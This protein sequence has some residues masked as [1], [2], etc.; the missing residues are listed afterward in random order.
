MSVTVITGGQYGSEGKGKVCAHLAVTDN[1][2]YMIRCG[3]PNSGHTV[4]VGG[5]RYKLRQVPAAFLNPHTRL[6]VAPGALVAPDVFLREVDVCGLDPSRI[7]IDGN[8]GIIEE[9]DSH[10]ERLSDLPLRLGSTGSGTGSAVSRRTIRDPS[11]RL[12]RH[13]P[14]LRP[15]ITSVREEI[16]GSVIR[17]K[18]VVIEGTQGFGLSLYHAE[19]WPY[20]TSRDTTAHSFLSEVGIGVRDYE[21]VMAI[22]TYP[23]RVA[24]NSGPLP[25]EITWEDVQEASGYPYPIAE[26]TTTTNRLRRVAKFD[27]S[28]VDQA[29]AANS[30]TRIALHGGDYID[31]ANHSV[32]DWHR[33]THSLQKFVGKIERRYKVPVSFIGTGPANGDIVDRRDTDSFWAANDIRSLQPNVAGQ[34]E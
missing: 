6:L 10:N 29:V 30:P 31:F 25:N 7:G 3:G 24:G 32:T 26:F 14:A 34:R 33:L 2:D 13:H 12:A 22:R 11:F 5:C 21:V 28:V 1:V 8:A 16:D 23:I 17:D 4:E 18:S 20:C 9:S 19:E 15:F 27:W